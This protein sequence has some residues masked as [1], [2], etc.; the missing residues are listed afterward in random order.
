[1]VPLHNCPSR[2]RLGA[3]DRVT[4]L[5]CIED[6]KDAT[7]CH[8]EDLLHLHPF[9]WND[10]SRSLLLP[11]SKVDIECSC[12]YLANNQKVIF[13]GMEMNTNLLVKEVVEAPIVENKP[14]SLPSSPLPALICKI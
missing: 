10:P 12:F 13:G 9:Q 3:L 14:T 1:M 11:V 2:V 5:D 7:L 8:F 6:L 4:A